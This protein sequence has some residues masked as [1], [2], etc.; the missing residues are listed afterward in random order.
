MLVTRRHLLRPTTGQH[1]RLREI[2]AQQRQLYNAALEERIGA[3]S[4]AGV[5]ITRLDQQKSLTQIRADDPEGL[6]TVALNVSRWTLKRLD[7]AF[8]AFFARA[9][10]GAKPGFPRFRGR[11]GWRSFGLLEWSGCRI[12]D[13]KI[14][15]KGIDRPLRVN[16]HREL[17]A[18]ARIL[19]VTFTLK[20]RRWFVSLQV[21]TNEGVAERHARPDT[22][23]GIDVGVSRLAAWDDG[24]LHGFVENARSRSKRAVELRRAQRALARCRRGSVRRRKVRERLRRLHE[25]V[26][27]ARSTHLHVEAERL[28]RRFATIVVEKLGLKNMTRSAAGTAAE[29]GANVRQK[30][31]L[32]ASILDASM[33]R[34]VQLLRYKAERAGGVVLDVDPRGTSQRCSDCGIRVPKALSVRTHDCR[35]CGL[36]VDR[37]VN[38]ARNVRAAGLAAITAGGGVV[39]PG[40]RNVGHRAVRAPGTLLAA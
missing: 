28:T 17:H 33:G 6:G 3:W 32:N 34:L 36:V 25:C 16:W 1:R 4:K 19:G 37:D 12:V 21:E 38:A 27:N 20:G 30:A 8:R 31:G 40:E 24:E 15:L 5:S 18:N 10:R 13:G 2:L 22:V 14:D 29:P 11:D 23:V 7:E 26:A 35:S 9:K 39:A